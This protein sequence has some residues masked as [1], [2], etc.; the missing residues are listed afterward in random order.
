MDKEEDILPLLCND[1]IFKSMFTGLESILSKFIYDVTGIT[2]S[3]DV[4]LYANEIPLRRGNEK[5]KRCDFIIKDNNR[6]IN[7]ELNASYSYVYLIKNTSYIFS[8]YATDASKGEDY[9]KDLEVVQININNYSR[10][11]K[12]ILNFM[13]LDTVNSITYLD[14]LKIFDLDIVKSK[15][16][17]YNE[18]ERKRIYLKWGALF[19]CNTIKEMEPILDELLSKTEKE[20]FIEKLNKITKEDYVMSEAEALRLENKIR[21]SL[22]KEG[23]ALG[24]ARGKAEGRAEGILNMIKSMLKNNASYEFISNV[25][26]KSI[27]EIKRIEKTI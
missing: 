10:F 16:M 8:L 21:R 26:G 3:N 4:K 9:N 1:V 2:L 12:P 6:I 20:I 11:N 14:S 24:E 22:R 17:Y 25:T 19:A 18:R 27:E 23:E 13:M 7:I 15:K 5:F